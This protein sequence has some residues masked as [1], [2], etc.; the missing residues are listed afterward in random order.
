MSDR[1]RVGANDGGRAGPL[2]LPV[3]DGVRLRDREAKLG[4]S[5]TPFALLFLLSSLSSL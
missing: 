5:Q 3:S 4:S 1:I 2:R